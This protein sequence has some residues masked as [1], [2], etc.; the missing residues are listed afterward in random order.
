MCVGALLISQ[1]APADAGKL[2]GQGRGAGGSVKRQSQLAKQIEQLAYDYIDCSIVL[3]YL[4]LSI[5][6]P[7]SRR[8]T[9]QSDQRA[10]FM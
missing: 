7:G 5:V 8:P 10:L 3:V 1:D 6:I 4:L 9:R 2:V